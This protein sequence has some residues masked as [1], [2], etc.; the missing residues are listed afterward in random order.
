MNLAPPTQIKV[1][2]SKSYKLL[3]VEEQSSSLSLGY[4]TQLAARQE[5]KLTLPLTRWP[6]SSKG[7]F[8]NLFTSRVESI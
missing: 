2:L 7:R 5:A 4:T 6:K 1:V 3:E 8:G